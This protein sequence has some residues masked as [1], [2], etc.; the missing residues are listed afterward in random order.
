M[1]TIKLTQ[2][3]YTVVDDDDFVKLSQFKWCA[4]KKYNNRFYAVRNTYE[5]GRDKPHQIYMH[6]VILK[7]KPRIKKVV[8]HIN[9]DPLDNRKI[10]L[11]IVN[12]AEN[13]KNK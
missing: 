7:V 10:N 13:L 6:H 9:N 3:K 1:K 5:N 11:R 2:G 8:D 12:R 4:N